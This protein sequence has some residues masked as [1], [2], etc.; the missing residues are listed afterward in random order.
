MPDRKLDDSQIGSV[1]L[2]RDLI[3]RLDRYLDWK[4]LYGKAKS[5]RNAAIRQALSTWLDDQEQLAGFL[6]RLYPFGIRT[7]VNKHL[8]FRSA[9][10]VFQCRVKSP[11]LKKYKPP[12]LKGLF[13]R[14]F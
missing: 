8:R 3:Q 10:G 13:Y 7:I 2:P 4:E 14:G 12:N 11:I 9:T 5:S 1:R 6:A